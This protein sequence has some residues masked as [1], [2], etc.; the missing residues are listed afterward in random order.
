MTTLMNALDR[1]ALTIPDDVRPGPGWTEQM[2]E[3][4]AHIGPRAVLAIV[5]AYG[6]QKIYISAD[7]ARCPFRDV[8]SAEHSAVISRVYNGAEYSVPTARSALARA[9]RA[10]IVAA[11][12]SGAMTAAEAARTLGIGRTYLAHLVNQSDEAAD[13]APMIPIRRPVDPRQIEMFP[14]DGD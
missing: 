10:P 7:P 3:M 14:P 6:G 9:R 13:T 1:P 12:R 8:L 5:E 4:A 11:V 2:L